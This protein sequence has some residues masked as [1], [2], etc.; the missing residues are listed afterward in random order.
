MVLKESVKNLLVRH[1]FKHGKI[2]LP[3]QKYDMFTNYKIC[4]GKYSMK[5]IEPVNRENV[6][7]FML[8]KHCEVIVSCSEKVAVK[9]CHKLS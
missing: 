6:R 2:G 4:D 3:R 7:S 8:G 5:L 1:P 9:S